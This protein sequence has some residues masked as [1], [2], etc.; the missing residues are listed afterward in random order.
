MC[1]VDCNH[2]VR[3]DSGDVGC[4]VGAFE[5]NSSLS[6]ALKES[7]EMGTEGSLI[8]WFLSWFLPELDSFSKVLS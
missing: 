2:V 4:A 5:Y 3:I 7:G 8:P 6:R 1:T